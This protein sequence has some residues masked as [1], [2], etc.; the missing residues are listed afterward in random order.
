MFLLLSLW[1]WRRAHYLILET[2][3]APWDVIVILGG[4]TERL[5]EAA[6]LYRHVHLDWGHIMRDA[7]KIEGI[8][9]GK[10][11]AGNPLLS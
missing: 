1:F 2:E 6:K 10:R 4:R 3:I 11:M 7:A 9:L 5:E 8:P